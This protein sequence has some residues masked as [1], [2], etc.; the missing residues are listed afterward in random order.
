[1][2]E[3]NHKFFEVEEELGKGDILE[4]LNKNYF[5]FGLA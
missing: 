2:V 5:G 1:M 3:E 4:L